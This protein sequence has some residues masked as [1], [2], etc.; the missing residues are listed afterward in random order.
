MKQYKNVNQGQS[1]FS[2]PGRIYL[3]ITGLFIKSRFIEEC[4]AEFLQAI[5][6]IDLESGMTTR[7]RG[8]SRSRGNAPKTAITHCM[9]G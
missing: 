4:Y 5:G 3:V 7:G 6:V 8:E 2:L 9:K 1:A